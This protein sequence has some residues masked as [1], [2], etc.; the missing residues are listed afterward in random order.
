MEVGRAFP[1]RFIP[2]PLEPR[3]EFEKGAEQG[4]TVV[5]HQLDQTGLLHQAAE[6]DQMSGPCPPVLDPLTGI[7]PGAGAIEAVTPHAQMPQPRR[8]CL[9]F[10]Q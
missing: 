1:L 2:F 6:F 10:R 8:C 5:V 9:K 7:G 3:G 4:G